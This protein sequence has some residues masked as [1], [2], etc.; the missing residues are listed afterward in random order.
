MHFASDCLPFRPQVLVVFDNPN[1]RYRF[2]STNRRKGNHRSTVRL[3]NQPEPPSCQ[4]GGNAG[5]DQSKIVAQL[6]RVVSRCYVITAE[7]GRGKKSYSTLDESEL[8]EI[9]TLCTSAVERIVG[10]SSTYGQQLDRTRGSNK[11]SYEQVPICIGVV[12]ALRDDI[13]DGCLERFRDLAHADIFGDLLSMAEHLLDSGYKD[14]AAVM[15]GGALE[16]HLRQLCLKNSVPIDLL[17]GTKT[18][19]KKADTMNADLA[20]GGVYN[21]TNQKHV[22][23]W[24]DIRNKAAHA[25]YD[26]YTH[27]DVELMRLGV[28]QFI[29]AHPA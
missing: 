6:D 29:E 23:A 17:T 22:V 20:K 14:A 12:K 13:A 5:M 27:K 28:S 21:V 7:V 11:D 10:M 19:P 2:I 9:L 8:T 26:K 4:L 1:E 15:V 25:E 3:P 16:S 18:V 24:L